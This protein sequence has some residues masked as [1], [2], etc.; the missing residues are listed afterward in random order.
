MSVKTLLL[1]LR[2]NWL[3]ILIFLIILALVFGTNGLSNKVLNRVGMGSIASY[4]AEDMAHSL[5][6]SGKSVNMPYYDE[7]FAPEVEDRQIIKT[8]N[9]NTEVERGDFQKAESQLKNIISSSDSFLLN[10]EVDKNGTGFKEY[11]I[12]RYQIKVEVTKYDSV[13]SQL[14]EI[15]EVQNFNEYTDDVTGSYTNLEIELAIERER[16]VRYQS[17]FNQATRIEDKITLN[18]MIFN[19]ERTIKYY[20]KR[21]ENLDSKIEY[22]TINLNISEEGS[23]FF[24]ASFVKISDLAKTFVSSINSVLIILFALIPYL[25]VLGLI[26]FIFKWFKSRKKDNQL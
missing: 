18:D 25:I 14:K 1:K 8:A 22:S 17:L 6:V 21:L 2:E 15:G 12:G 9:L 23:N 5:G 19:Q 26:Y 20:E 3:L 7:G 10:E 11:F 16:L 4:Q 24:E 13:I